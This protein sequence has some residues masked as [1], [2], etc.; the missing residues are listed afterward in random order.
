[1]AAGFPDPV[2][3]AIPTDGIIPVAGSLLN[4]TF[5]VI[6]TDLREGTLHSWNVA[7]QR[8]LPYRFTI[9]VAYV[10]NRGVDLV[11]DVNTNAG[12][13]YGTNNA[14]RPQFA[15]F[16][17]TGQTRTR[18]NRNKSE[19]NSLQM[20]IDRRFSN[21]LLVTNSYTLSRSMDYAN[22]NGGIATPIDFSKSWGR[23]NFDRTHNYVATAIYELPWGPRKRWLNKGVLGQVIGGWQ[24]S[25]I[26]VGQSGTPLSIN[27]SG[28]LFAT[29]DNSAYA[30][31]IGTE[32]IL[33][34]LGPGLLYFDPTA[35]AQPAAA[36]QG[37]MKRN[38]G[39]EGPGFWNLDMSLFKRFSVGAKRYAEI[40]VDAY[41]APNAV[42]WGN[43]NTTFSTNPNNTFGQ[44]G[45]TTGGQRSLR[46]GAR[47]VF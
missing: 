3:L 20:K 31:L 39:P 8:E 35:Y 46:F 16:N 4:S 5:D 23:S 13:S 24:L 6:P 9:D 1:M 42:R 22:E 14:G 30:D 28:S 32:R 34:N 38:S 37:N 25:G 44:I 17:R 41:D 36:T 21:G 27:A 15:S 12:M 10:G 33:G 40:H 2:L 45:G 11:M 26:F 43:P 47:Y 18:T 7:F 29:P 19:Y